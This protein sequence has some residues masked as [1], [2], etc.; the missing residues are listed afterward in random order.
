M[1]YSDCIVLK[2]CLVFLSVIA[3]AKQTMLF[4]F[5]N[6]AF[7]N[8]WLDV[9][10][11]KALSAQSVPLHKLKFS[12]KIHIFMTKIIGIPGYSHRE[13]FVCCVEK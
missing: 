13:Y 12:I 1:F 3:M 5:D 10:N 7:I 11:K 2:L 6:M 8:F 9:A 4:V